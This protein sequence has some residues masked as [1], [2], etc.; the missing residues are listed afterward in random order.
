MRFFTYFL[1]A[2]SLI[3]FPDHVLSQSY[4]PYYDYEANQMEIEEGYLDTCFV[5]EPEYFFGCDCF[6][7]SRNASPPWSTHPAE[8]EPH[9]CYH[10][11]PNFN[12]QQWYICTS[13]PRYFIRHLRGYSKH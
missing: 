6:E 4:G 13:N 3:V 11:Y 12:L 8:R 5:H 10:Y 2:S 1:A 7:E 9:C